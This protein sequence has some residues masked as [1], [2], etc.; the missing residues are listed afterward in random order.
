MWKNICLSRNFT[1]K[2]L[3]C[4]NH[5][6]YLDEN[7]ELSQQYLGNLYKLAF[8]LQIL[9]DKCRFPLF[10]NS[11]FRCPS[12]NYAVGGAAKSSHLVGL[13]ADIRLPGDSEKQDYLFRAIGHLKEYGV[14]SYVEVNLVS[15][16][17]HISVFNDG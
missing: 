12:L 8:V 5:K 16:Y 10:I 15:Q 11:G 9:R 17:I 1:L 14:I 13:A 6:K 4:T 7:R 3:T 2:E